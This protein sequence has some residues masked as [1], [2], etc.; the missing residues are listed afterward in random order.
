M[1]VRACFISKS[2]KS[3]KTH[4]EK[5]IIYNDIKSTKVVNN[6][7]LEQIVAFL[8]V[9]P[10]PG[11]RFIVLVDCA[12]YGIQIETDSNKKTTL[13]QHYLHYNGKNLVSVNSRKVIIEWD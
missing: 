9:N 5:S 10:K 11:Y 13:F 6:A 4:S 8:P 7:I 1:F 12:R 2:V 3:Y